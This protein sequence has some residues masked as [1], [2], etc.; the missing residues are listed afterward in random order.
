MSDAPRSFWKE[1]KQRKV[2]RVVGVY[3]AV[4]WAIV[5]GASELRQILELPAWVPQ[6]VLVLAGL[7]LPAAMVLA[8]AFEVTPEGV[9]RT[10]PRDGATVGPS[11]RKPF[12]LGAVAGVATLS[13][14]AFL[15]RGSV[16]PGPEREGPELDE[17]LVAI[18]PSLVSSVV[19]KLAVV[20]ARIAEMTLSDASF[21]NSRPAATATRRYAPSCTGQIA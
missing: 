13:L 5:L 6:V 20:A 21:R 11:S 17:A 18:V 4:A 12:V 8:W 2:V 9:R 16:K 1:L 15:A 14:V 3:A 10:L 19:V 7:G